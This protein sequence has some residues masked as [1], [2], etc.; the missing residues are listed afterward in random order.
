MGKKDKQQKKRVRQLGKILE[1]EDLSE[2]EQYLKDEREDNELTHSHARIQYIPPFVLAASHN[3]PEKVKDSQN[4]KNKKFV[5]HL[6]QHVEKHLLKE[7]QASSGLDLH[8]GKPETL[9][10]FDTITWKYTDDQCLESDEGKFKVQVV[11][12]CNSDGAAI[13]VSYD[14]IP[15]EDVAV[16]L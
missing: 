7:I 11:V 10:D 9:E 1:F 5:R 2:F 6:H 8:F 4:R 12:K 16:H 14:A 13:D 15:M 3:D